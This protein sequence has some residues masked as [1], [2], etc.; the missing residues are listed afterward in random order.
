M[1]FLRALLNL[2]KFWALYRR[3]AAFLR[4]E[5]PDAVVLI[6]YPG[7]NWWIARAAKREGIPVF[8][9]V[10]PQ[11]WAWARWR[12]KKM[13]RLVDHVLCAL[14]FEQEWYAARGCHATL[15]GHPFFDEAS[16]HV[17]DAEF[18]AAL[19]RR[20]AARAGRMDDGRPIPLVTILPGSRS[21]EITHNLPWLLKAAV[22]IRRAVPDAQFA[23][24][25]L[26]PAFAEAVRRE[27]AGLGLEVEV[28]VGR[29]PELIHAATC[30]LSK[31]GSV[32]L[33]LLYHE[34]PTVI[35]YYLA[36]WAYH[37]GQYLAKVRY[38]TL[39]NLLATDR[40]FCERPQPYD[41][42]SAEA[43]EVLFPEYA[44]YEDKS[45]QLAAHA[46]EWLTQPARRAALVARLAALK[47]KVARPGAA[48][49]Y[50]LGQLS[51]SAPVPSPHLQRQ[52]AASASRRENAAG[53]RR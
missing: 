32:S 2:H 1:W 34:K 27:A 5:R 48:A 33:E 11:V 43:A 10:P 44:T 47:E 26:K 30:C 4:Q 45:P 35:L 3:A 25:A 50:V 21:Q 49:D 15:V 19:R 41:P 14:P 40:P 9:Y 37:L 31:S 12:V 16:R 46:I 6:D 29:T 22:H 51:R 53:A 24:A 7:F 18:L 42:A 20:M 52:F 36:R 38:M 8:Y 39:V 13:R 28:H 17:L 23:V